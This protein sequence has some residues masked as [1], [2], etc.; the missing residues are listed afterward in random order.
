MHL[1]TPTVLLQCLFCNRLLSL[2]TIF[3]DGGYAGKLEAFVQRMG[4]LIDAGNR[5]KV[6]SYTLALG[7]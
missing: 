4:R 5:Q 1:P 2:L 7:D 6:Q 3:T